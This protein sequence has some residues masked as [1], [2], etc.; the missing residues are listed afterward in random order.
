MRNPI[1]ILL[2]A[3]MATLAV[4]MFWH[5]SELDKMQ[6]DYQAYQTRNKNLLDGIDRGIK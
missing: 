2:L 3:I 4:L 1:S 5:E 6:H